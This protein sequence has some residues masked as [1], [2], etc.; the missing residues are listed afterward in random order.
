MSHSLVAPQRGRKTPAAVVNFAVSFDK[1]MEA[2]L[3]LTGTPTLTVSPA[4]ALTATSPAVTAA[5]K[6]I[7]GKSVPAGRAVT[8]VC[9]GGLANNTYRVK[10]S[11]QNNATPAET[12][13]GFVLIDVADN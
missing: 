9:A 10:V 5:A 3:S 4:A 8:F 12:V 7:L 13:E 11:C 1:F 6:T 2:G